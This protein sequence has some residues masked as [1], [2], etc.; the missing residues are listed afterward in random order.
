MSLVEYEQ[1]DGCGTCGY[2]R[3]QGRNL[4]R[5]LSTYQEALKTAE[6]LSKQRPSPGLAGKQGRA[7]EAV[8]QAL[9][10]LKTFKLEQF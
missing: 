9:N 4:Y 2:E 3:A 8:R 5:L 10:A 7:E 6:T 1:C